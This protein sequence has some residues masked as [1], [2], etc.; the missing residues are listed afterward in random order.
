M[1]CERFEL[2]GDAKVLEDWWSWESKVYDF[3]L[4]LFIQWRN[5]WRIPFVTKESA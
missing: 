5:V 3:I 2:N 1:G 4:T